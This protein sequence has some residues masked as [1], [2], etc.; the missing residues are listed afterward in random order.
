MLIQTFIN[1]IARRL[2]DVTKKQ[3]DDDFLL[4]ATNASLA[5]LTRVMPQAF[6]VNRDLTL[7]SG[8]EQ[9]IDGDLHKIVTILHNVKADG[10]PGRAVTK[11]DM[12][13]LDAAYPQWRQDAPREYIRHWMTDEFDEQRFYVWPPAESGREVTAGVPVEP[14]IADYTTQGMVAGQFADTAIGGQF[15]TEDDPAYDSTEGPVPADNLAFALSLSFVENTEYDILFHATPEEGHGLTQITSGAFTP[16]ALRVRFNGGNKIGFHDIDG[17][18][19]GY[20]TSPNNQD[21]IHSAANSRYSW[22]IGLGLS[23]INVVEGTL[24]RVTADTSQFNARGV[25]VVGVAQ[26]II[27]NVIDQAAYDA[28]YA[29]YQSDLAVYNT[30]VAEQ[31]I[32]HVIRGTFTKTPRIDTLPAPEVPDEPAPVGELADTFVDK[33]PDFSNC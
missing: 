19:Y 13:V 24:L 32:G 15:S 29:Q 7:V 33:Y 22:L 17:A 6:S 14:D 20:N 4:S 1:E 10:S 12:S 9:V 2:R 26:P 28:A 31:A 23:D 27:E 11:A 25:N 30:A 8:T 18:G 3:W 16:N 5:A 21:I